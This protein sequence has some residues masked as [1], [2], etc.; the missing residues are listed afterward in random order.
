MEGKE[1]RG[2]IKLG[3]INQSSDK[4]EKKKILQDLVITGNG[5]DKEITG[6][7]ERVRSCLTL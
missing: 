4:G 6:G 5:D 3:N 7:A 1:T 2:K